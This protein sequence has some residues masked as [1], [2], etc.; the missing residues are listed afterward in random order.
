MLSIDRKTPFPTLFL[1]P[2]LLAGWPGGV[3]APHIYAGSTSARALAEYDANQDGF[4]DAQELEA[5]PGLKSCLARYDTDKDGRL[6]RAELETSLAAFD[7]A[8]VGLLDTP[9]T[10]TLDGRPLEGAGVVFEPEP[11]LADVIK[12]ARG[13]TDAGGV[14]RM[15]TEGAPLPGCN[16][17]IYRV[18]ISKPDA[19][20]RETLPARYNARTQ[21]GI[22]LG[23]DA[24]GPCAFDLA[25]TP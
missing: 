14:A 13:T 6:S 12:P 24:K 19:G 17:G 22:E 23:P 25:S 16:L 2:P 10:V 11:F 15:K 21:L 18:R 9:F 20:G 8:Q 3:A 5:S 7:Q 4:L 1:L